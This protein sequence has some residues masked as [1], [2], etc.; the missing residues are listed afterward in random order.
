MKMSELGDDEGDGVELGKGVM[1]EMEGK[2]EERVMEKEGGG[3]DEGG[4]RVELG[5]GGRER[6]RREWWRKEGGGNDEG[7]EVEEMMREEIEWS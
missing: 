6:G 5:K 2:G 4:D 1:G 3:D 7:R